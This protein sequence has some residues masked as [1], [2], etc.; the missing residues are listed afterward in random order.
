MKKKILMFNVFA[1]AVYLIANVSAFMLPTHEYLDTTAIATYQGQ[2]TS[3]YEACVKHPDLCFIGNSLTDISVVY[4]YTYGSQGGGQGVKYEITH[5]P[6]FCVSM[7]KNAVG[8]ADASQEEEFACAVGA[9]IHASQ[10]FISHTIMVPYA[11]RHTFLPN[12]IIHVFS[13]QHLDNYVQSNYPEVRGQII[14]LSPESWDKCIPLLKRTLNGYNEYESDLREGKTDDLINTFIAEI[15][16]SVDPNS[17]T[18]YDLAFKNKVSIF[19]KLGLIPAGFFIVYLS[20]IL[21]FTLL[22]VLLIF[23]KDK[24]VINYISI[25]IFGGISLLLITLL[26]SLLLGQAFNFFVFVIKPISNLVPIGSPQTILDQ[27][28]QSTQMLFANGEDYIA[29]I[30]NP[31]VA[32]GFQELA[33][34]NEDIK[35]GSYIIGSILLLLL[36]YL[37]YLNFKKSNSNINS[38]TPFKL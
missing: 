30:D 6:G 16:R 4:Y 13:E 33:K 18:S 37:I 32:S 24:K 27:S 29:S 2:S 28:I 26:V 12:G 19:G 23:R 22:T 35:W 14:G 36:F 3:F 15:S 31:K 9:C 11:I 5:S 21:L 38:T 25:I 20:I 1:I 34:A 7:L 17:G 10:D 8:S